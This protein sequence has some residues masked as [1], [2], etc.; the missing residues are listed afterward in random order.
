MD[1][2]DIATLA[3]LFFGFILGIWFYDYILHIG[4]RR[5]HIH[6]ENGRITLTP[7]SPTPPEVSPQC[8]I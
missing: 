8:E 3:A 2:Q 4:L 6:L 7:H 5:Y 1:P